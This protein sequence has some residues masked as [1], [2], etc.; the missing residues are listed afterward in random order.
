LALRGKESWDQI[1]PTPDDVRQVAHFWKDHLE[2]F[3]GRQWWPKPVQVRAAIDAL[4]VGFGGTLRV[5]DME[6][7]P[8]WG[9]FSAEHVAESSTAR[10]VRGYAA[11]LEVVARHFADEVRGAAVLLEGDNQGAISA[12]NHLRSPN[13]GINETLRTVFNICCDGNFDVVAKWVPR[14]DL[15]EADEL[16]RR[17]DSS[18][19]GLAEAECERAFWHFGVPP[20]VDL[21]ASDIHHVT[22]RFVSQF[23]IP[24][25]LAI[26]AFHQ[27]WEELIGPG[28]AWLFPPVRYV[29]RALSLIESAKKEALIFLPIKSG[30]NELIQLYRLKGASVSPPLEIPRES[31][32]CV[33]SCRVLASS[34]KPSFLGLGIVRVRWQ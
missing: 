33:P 29:S 28:I 21:F 5:K 13:Q 24:G 26:D 23:H 25:C 20:T 9:T 31:S 10:E 11:A 2:S 6:P 32:S 14:D 3:N 22:D 12:L 17:L 4:G 34:L 19:W 8:F 27:S 15:T 30:S 18:D 1:F 16:L 7:I